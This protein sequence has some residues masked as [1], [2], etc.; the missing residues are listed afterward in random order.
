MKQ[1]SPL[2]PK[3]K[4]EMKIFLASAILFLIICP[5]C[6][7]AENKISLPDLRPNFSALLNRKDSTLSLDSFYFIRIDTINEKKALTHQRFSFLHI[8]E[9]L[10]RQL[11]WMSNKRDSFHSVPS[12]SDIQTI[13]YLNGEKA[14][15]GREI[16]SLSALI[17]DADSITPIGY[18]A[19]YKATVRK[20]DIFV[21]SDTVP[22]AI[23]LKMKVSDWDRNL[24]KIT[25]S[26]A[27]GKPFRPIGIHL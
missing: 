23:S 21:V 3:I 19:L 2:V 4:S 12:A 7:P 16:D 8:M 10:N 24:E 6:K 13:D 25:D 18:R 9:N 1:H 15:V 27:I 17:S 14:Y 5:G 11:E 26:L 20:K 22:Y